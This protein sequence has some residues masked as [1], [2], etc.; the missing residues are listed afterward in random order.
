MSDTPEDCGPLRLAL[1]PEL[2]IAQAADLQLQLLKHLEA[3]GGGLILDLAAVQE[4]D[5]AGLQ[6][7]IAT[8]RSLQELGLPLQL[9]QPSAVVRAALQCYGLDPQL[10]PRAPASSPAVEEVSP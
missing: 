7:L 4:F 10:Q 9:D 2:T 5:S 6:L 1:G 3:P 8:G